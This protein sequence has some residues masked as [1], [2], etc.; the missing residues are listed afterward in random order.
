MKVQR[1]V[2]ERDL[3][4]LGSKEERRKVSSSFRPDSQLGWED[5][6]KQKETHIQRPNMKKLSRRKL[7]RLVPP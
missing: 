2:P 5:G 6:T 1:K 7:R 4:L 3:T